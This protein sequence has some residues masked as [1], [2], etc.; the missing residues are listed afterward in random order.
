MSTYLLAG[1][2]FLDNMS[3]YNKAKDNYYLNMELYNETGNG[4][5]KDLTLGYYDDA[6]KS[7]ENMYVYGIL[8]FT[9][10]FLSNYY[11][12]NSKWFTWK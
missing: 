12:S 4:K 5:Y 7:E 3:K 8:A 10:N 6:T 9:I 11:I 2:S 1:V